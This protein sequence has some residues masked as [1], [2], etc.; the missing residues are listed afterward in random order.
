MER[1]VFAVRYRKLGPGPVTRPKKNIKR[2]NGTKPRIEV[3]S[4]PKNKRGD[5]YAIA[6]NQDRRGE[7]VLG[8]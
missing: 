2:E 1:G 6:L 8:A 5:F 7:W 4:K 3:L